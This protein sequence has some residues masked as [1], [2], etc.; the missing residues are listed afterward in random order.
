MKI[1][2]SSGF[3]YEKAMPASPED[4]F[5]ESEVV[6]EYEGKKR[7][8][9]VT[10]VRYFDTYLAENN[11]YDADQTGVSFYEVAALLILMKNEG[12]VAGQR[13][14]YSDTEQFMAAFDQEEIDRAMEIYRGLE[15]T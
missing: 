8:L 4:L 14:Y 2:Q 12:Y 5:N 11:I 6:Y 10:Y 13:L 7:T 15:T 9:T 1:F 3:E